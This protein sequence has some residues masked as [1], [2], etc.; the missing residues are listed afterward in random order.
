MWNKS[1]IKICIRYFN[2]A[3]LLTA[4]SALCVN[5]Y[6]MIL[7]S[8]NTKQIH[9]IHISQLSKIHTDFSDKEGRGVIYGRYCIRFINLSRK[10]TIFIET[11]IIK[12]G[13]FSDEYK[14][15]FLFELLNFKP[16]QRVPKLIY[17]K[18]FHSNWLNMSFM[19]SQI[20]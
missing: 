18:D 5:Y 14:D 20:S 19:G 13:Y 9:W 11:I 12:R 16:I 4:P 2:I 15:P 8:I 17:Q 7:T 6:K 1:K 3:A 10:K